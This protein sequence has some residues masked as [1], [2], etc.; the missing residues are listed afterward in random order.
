VQAAREVSCHDRVPREPILI[1]LMTRA[2]LGPGICDAYSFAMWLL[3]NIKI[4]SRKNRNN[5]VGQRFLF[6]ENI[7]FGGT[8]AAKSLINP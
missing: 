5:S 6:G 3:Q 1:G 7:A 2:R 4:I 8:R